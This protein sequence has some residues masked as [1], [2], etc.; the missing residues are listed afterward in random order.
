MDNNIKL[1]TGIKDLNLRPASDDMITEEADGTRVFHVVQT[2]PMHCPTC[3][4]LMK[5]NG[6][7]IRHARVKILPVAGHPAVLDIKKQK[8]ICPASEA[9]PKVVTAVAKVK[10]IKPGHRIADIVNQHIAF[11]FEKTISQKELGDMHFVSDNT[12]GRV[13]KSCQSDFKL[14]HQWL[15]KAIAFDDF[16]SGKFA[17]SGMSM[18]L[19]NPVNHRT[20]DVIQSRRSRFLRNYFLSNFTRKARFSVQLVVVDL[21][22]PYRPL[23]HDLFPNAHIIADH[24][25][26]ISQ[27]YRALQAVRI[28][29][30]KAF[31]PK[32]HEYRALKR[33][34]K[35]LMQRTNEV[36]YGHFYRRANFGYAQLSNSEILDR[37]LA[38]SPE[39]VEAYSYYQRLLNAMDHGDTAQL[40]SLL[41]QKWTSLPTPFQKVQRTLRR[42]FSEIVNSFKYALTN[43]PLEG[44]NNKIKVIKRI[45][46]GFRNFTNFRLRILISMRRSNL[47][48]KQKASPSSEAA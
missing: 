15:P 10:G 34:W 13:L 12:V 25:H 1:L 46:Y 6:F 30:M 38:M 24:F 9:C 8:F 14:V 5:R 4:R 29:V 32:T 36:D 22:Q 35:L 39:L 31:G 42:H 11:S 40:Q 2:Y 37:L 3:G 19:M 7:R 27:A 16:K 20:I 33:F 28:K 26:V 17:P 45:A 47:L 21:F 44:T 48:S 43:G 41:S 23:I 18:I